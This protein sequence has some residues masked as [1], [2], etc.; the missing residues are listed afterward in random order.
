[1]LNP[2]IYSLRKKDVKRGLQIHRK[3]Y[4][5]FSLKASVQY[6]SY[7]LGD[8]LQTA[9]CVFLKRIKC[10]EMFNTYSEIAF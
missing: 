6:E 10:M 1:M 2:L 5:I 7:N 3:E 4:A 8:G 9:L